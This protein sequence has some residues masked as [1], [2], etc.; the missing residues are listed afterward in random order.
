M[1]QSK[2]KP[3]HKFVQW[4]KEATEVNSIDE[5]SMIQ[6]FK[7]SLSADERVYFKYLSKCEIP[8]LTMLYH[9]CEIFRNQQY[10]LKIREQRLRI[11]VE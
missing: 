10:K 9:N 1:Q 4:F 2:G 3:L 6:S 8:S 11:E 7:I 5:L